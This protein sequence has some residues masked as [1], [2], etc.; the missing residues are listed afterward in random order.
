MIAVLKSKGVRNVIAVHGDILDNDFRVE[1]D[2]SSDFDLIYA[3]S[4]CSFLPDY[5]SA[6][7][8]LARLLKR[9]GY[10]VQLDWKRFDR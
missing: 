9:G 5:E 4:V 8:A 6:I 3:S 10:F 2:S 7:I 1:R